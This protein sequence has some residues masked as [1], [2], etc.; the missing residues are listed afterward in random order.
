MDLKKII[1]VLILAGVSILPQHCSAF[2][3]DKFESGMSLTEVIELAQKENIVLYKSSAALTQKGIDPIARMFVNREVNPK[4]LEDVDRVSYGINL[5]KKWA[6]V[7]MLFTPTSKRL[8]SIII[9]WT[10]YTADGLKQRQFDPEFTA[11]VRLSLEKKYGEAVENKKQDDESTLFKT[12]SC[13]W[14]IGGADT[15]SMTVD[16]KSLRLVYNNRTITKLADKESA[17]IEKEAAVKEKIRE[18]EDKEKF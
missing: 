4:F 15:I 13:Y 8:A 18:A 14:K 11:D 9:Q 5:L 16:F 12:Y 3:F 1:P 2:R 17:I 6:G 10:E 7:T